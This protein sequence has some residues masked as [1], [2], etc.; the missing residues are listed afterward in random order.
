MSCRADTHHIS[1][2]DHSAKIYKI[3]VIICNMALYTENNVDL[4]LAHKRFSLSIG[5]SWD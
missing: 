4:V 2:H 5:L 3:R 1:N